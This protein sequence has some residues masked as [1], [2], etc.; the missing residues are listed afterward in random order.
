MSKL[1]VVLKIISAKDVLHAANLPKNTYLL[2]EQKV[3]LGRYHLKS[4]EVRNS[5][6]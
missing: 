4:E 1:T 3:F 2:F 6:S 5:Q